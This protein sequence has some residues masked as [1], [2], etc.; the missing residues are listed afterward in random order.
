MRRRGG[1]ISADFV[2]LYNT[3]LIKKN[4]N[5]MFLKLKQKFKYSR[6]N[7]IKSTKSPNFHLEERLAGYRYW[8]GT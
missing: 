2:L 8:Y 4:F 3:K 6:T 7:S 5:F 1:D